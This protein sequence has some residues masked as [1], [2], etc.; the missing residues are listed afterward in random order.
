MPASEVLAPVTIPN[1]SAVSRALHKGGLTV[2]SS[3]APA[4]LKGIRVSRAYRAVSVD[5]DGDLRSHRLAVAETARTILTAAG[6]VLGDLATD[7]FVGFH[8]TGRQSH[9]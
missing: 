9:A 2:L 8:I 6:Y 1:A 3:G 5:I 4:H 7:P